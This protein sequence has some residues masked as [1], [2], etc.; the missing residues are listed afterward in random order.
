M[1]FQP[2]EELS[3]NYAA[4]LPQSGDDPYRIRLE[5]NFAENPVP[6]AFNAPVTNIIREMAPTQQVNFM[7]TPLTEFH[8]STSF[9]ANCL[10]VH[11]VSSIRDMHTSDVNK[12]DLLQKL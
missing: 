8:H 12:I 7:S 2:P 4:S 10:Q 6:D 3:Q 5:P 11:Q 1:P 9:N